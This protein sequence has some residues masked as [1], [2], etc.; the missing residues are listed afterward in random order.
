MTVL[1]RSGGWEGQTLG[2]CHCGPCEFLPP[3]ASRK[4]WTGSPG[5]AVGQPTCLG[6]PGPRPPP[7]PIP[8][9]L[10][11]DRRDHRLVLPSCQCW[12]QAPPPRPPCA[13]AP[14]VVPS[15]SAFAVLAALCPCFSLGPGLCAGSALA[16]HVADGRQ[17]FIKRMDG[18]SCVSAPRPV[19]RPEHTGRGALSQRRASWGPRAADFTNRPLRR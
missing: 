1:P 6:L 18:R 9:W 5:P 10:S 19:L 3:W 11:R 7:A 17:V 2:I 16:W 4:S 8:P 12:G 14:P 15:R 13:P